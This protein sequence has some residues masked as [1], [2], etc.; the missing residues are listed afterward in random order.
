MRLDF[1]RMSLRPFRMLEPLLPGHYMSVLGISANK[2]DDHIFNSPNR[3]PCTFMHAHIYALM[4]MHAHMLMH[5][6]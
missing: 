1:H 5:A 2:L 6:P 3:D 4:H